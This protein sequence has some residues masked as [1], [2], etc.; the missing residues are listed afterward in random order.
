[1]ADTKGDLIKIASQI[2]IGCPISRSVEDWQLPKHVSGRQLYLI[3]QQ[4]DK[5]DSW[6]KSMC[7]KVRSAADT[8]EGASTNTASQVTCT[9]C[10]H[11]GDDW[12]VCHDCCY[13]CMS[14]YTPRKT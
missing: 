11:E 12:G 13:R 9:T 10:Q 8:M 3:Q 1:M 6:L 14:E 5:L 2:L 7:I 4:L